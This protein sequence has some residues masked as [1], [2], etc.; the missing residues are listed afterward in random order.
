MSN[1]RNTLKLITSYIATITIFFVLSIYFTRLLLIANKYYLFIVIPILFMSIT[2]GFINL[3]KLILTII[4]LI[5]GRND[6]EEIPK[7]INRVIYNVNQIYK[8][9]LIGIFIALITSVM[10]LD[11]MLCV[12]FENYFLLTISIVIW[13][14][15]YYLIFRII[16]GVI[17]KEI[18]L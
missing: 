11:I 13:I 15:L 8:Y 1:K 4:S 12:T 9:T 5:F 17:K 2:I 10:I 3:I 6:N 14:L 16:V 18:S 7:F